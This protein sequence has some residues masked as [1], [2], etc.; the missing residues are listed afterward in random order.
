MRELTQPHLPQEE[1]REMSFYLI[2]LATALLVGVLIGCTLFEQLLAAR[3]RRQAAVQR[4]L[5]SQWQ[6]L[7]RH[8]REFE[9]AQQES[10]HWQ[11]MIGS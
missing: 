7:E 11:G 4:D 2:V 10:P 5:N 8:W 3:T 9:A 1:G 6:E